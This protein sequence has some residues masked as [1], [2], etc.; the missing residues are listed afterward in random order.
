MGRGSC[1]GR[2]P[3]VAVLMVPDLH[4]LTFPILPTPHAIVMRNIKEGVRA[5][6]V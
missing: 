4:V 6:N 3:S 1:A 2:T 5:R